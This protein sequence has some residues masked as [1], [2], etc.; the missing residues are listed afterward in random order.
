MVVPGDCASAC[1]DALDVFTRFPNTILIGAPSSADSTYMEV[2]TVELPSN[3]AV[4]IVPNKMYVNRGRANGQI[5]PAAIEVRDVAWS[6]DSLLRTVEADL[7][8]RK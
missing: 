2:R 5:Y 7:A 8:K 6:V 4:V 1:L 3:L